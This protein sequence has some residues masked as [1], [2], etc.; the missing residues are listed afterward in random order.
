MSGIVLDAATAAKL[1]GLTGP[2]ELYGP[3]GRVVAMCQ[4]LA[5]PAL[6][7]AGQP[8]SPFT[9]DEE[10]GGVRGV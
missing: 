10:A 8:P 3:D 9:A 4:P 1:A 2:V 5:R 7:S 6:E